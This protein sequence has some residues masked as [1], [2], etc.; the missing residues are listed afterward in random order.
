MPPP[1]SH[2]KKGALPARGVH[3][4]RRVPRLRRYTATLIW[5]A[6]RGCSATAPATGAQSMVQRHRG[7]GRSSAGLRTSR[8][9]P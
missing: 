2:V 3:A 4:Y 7:E 9:R 1:I 5:P 8:R 6:F